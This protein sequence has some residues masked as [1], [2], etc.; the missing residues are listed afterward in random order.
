MEIERKTRTMSKATWEKLDTTGAAQS[1]RMF[2]EFFLPLIENLQFLISEYGFNEP[3]VKLVSR[4]GWIRF[5]KQNDEIKIGYEPLSLPWGYVMRS[6]NDEAETSPL[7]ELMDR[8][9]FR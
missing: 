1:L 4:E 8:Y 9:G 6:K 5:N 7:N 2:P 3:V